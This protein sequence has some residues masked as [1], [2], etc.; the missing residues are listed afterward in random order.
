MTSVKRIAT[1]ADLQALANREK[2]ADRVRIGAAPG[3]RIKHYVL[4]CTGGGCIA[5]GALAVKAALE[6]AVKQ[7]GLSAGVRIFET[8]C[9]GPCAVGPIVLR[10]R[11]RPHGRR[12][13][14]AGC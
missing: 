3:G 10:L 5:S 4:V 8:G 9:L 13:L 1:P 14:L 6:A 11:R 12:L 7:A 2:V